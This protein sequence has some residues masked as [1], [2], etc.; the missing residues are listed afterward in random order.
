MG[1]FLTNQ[2]S[3]SAKV[4]EAEDLDLVYV[5]RKELN[6][7]LEHKGNDLK[8]LRKKKVTP[9]LSKSINDE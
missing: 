3:L 7:K 9:L 5:Q 1:Y 6:S 8:K 2:G 4:N